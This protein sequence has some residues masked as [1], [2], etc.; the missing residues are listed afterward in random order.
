MR[1]NAASSLVKPNSKNL[2]FSA[3]QEQAV[4]PKIFVSIW[5][6]KLALD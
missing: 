1:H 5:Q 3:F 2:K 4:K 6:Q